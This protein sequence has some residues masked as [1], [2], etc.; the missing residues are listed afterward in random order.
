MKCRISLTAAF[1]LVTIL[2]SVCT[3][4]GA[5]PAEF[6]FDS[7]AAQD[8]IPVDDTLVTAHGAVML[9][10]R[11][12][13][14]DAARK[15][16]ATILTTYRRIRIGKPDGRS[17]ADVTVPHYHKDQKVKLI[18]GRTIRHNGDTVLLAP[19][20]I[21][22]REVFR[23]QGMKVKQVSF[24]MP[25]VS[26]DCIIEYVVKLQVPEPYDL[27]VIQK[28]LPMIRGQLRWILSKDSDK[29]SLDLGI[30]TI[31]WIP[32]WVWLNMKR[33]IDVQQ[34]PSIKDVNELIFTVDSVAA[35][36]HEEHSLPE[37]A[38]T[39]QLR[40]YYGT[41]GSPA[42]FWSDQAEFVTR[43]F[44]AFVEKSK[45]IKKA[46]SQ[47]DSTLSDEENT[48]LACDWARKRF[49]NV[50]YMKD[51]DPALKKA[52]HETADE[53][54]KS[55][56]CD[57][58]GINYIFC[59]LLR[60]MNIDA[61]I[62]W[63]RDRDE[64]LLVS[65]AKYWQFDRNLVAVP[66]SNRSWTFYCPGDIYSSNGQVAWY[67]EGITGLMNNL[68]GDPFIVVPFSPASINRTTRSFHVT[69]NSEFEPFG[70]ISERRVG[71]PA[72]PL[73]AAMHNVSDAEKVDQ[74]KSSFTRLLPQAEMDSIV[75]E[76]ADSA[77]LPLNIECQVTYPPVSSELAGDRL[78]VKPLELLEKAVNPFVPEKRH[79]TIVMEYAF[80]TV[81][82]LMLDLPE[83]WKLEGVPPDTMFSNSVGDCGVR[84]SN[85][86]SSIQVQRLFRINR[87]FVAIEDYPA[88]QQLYQALV[89]LN[90]LT[91]T[92][93]KAPK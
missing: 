22:E 43:R 69:L 65:E 60:E 23:S 62:V 5:A 8:W 34:L 82:A 21:M 92:L 59:D 47:F 45:E 12:V 88:A 11:V 56:F 13:V 37:N 32:N 48:L 18:L 90:G 35:F 14:D 74:V 84:F 58:T 66:D 81:E 20:Q 86:E 70:S 7:I 77:N 83:G 80:E 61:R 40:M 57:R 71:Q 55:G 51:D 76:N 38:L 27:W 17:A 46:A 53:A 75:W 4:R 49:R 10:D 67:N 30:F 54:F 89:G 52:K 2:P 63:V 85:L 64:D 50:T 79:N 72:R 73:R 39:G 33:R 24:S 41:G 91:I 93:Q 26:D 78:L 15:D 1:C 9:F 68:E 29:S 19:E 87:P 42:A 31:N 6:A 44:D 28:D 36:E 16:Y 3:A 25:G